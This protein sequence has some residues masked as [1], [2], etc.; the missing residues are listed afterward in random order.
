MFS[1]NSISPLFLG[2]DGIRDG[3]SGNPDRDFHERES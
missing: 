3:G 2:D 1:G